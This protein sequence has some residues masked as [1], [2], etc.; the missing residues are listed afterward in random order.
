MDEAVFYP[1]KDKIFINAHF[2]SFWISIEEFKKYNIPYKIFK[3]PDEK[4]SCLTEFEGKIR[5]IK[6]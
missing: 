6:I 1:K 3:E 5:K 4:K 2:Y